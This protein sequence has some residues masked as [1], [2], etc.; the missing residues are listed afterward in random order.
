[1]ETVIQWISR[2]KTSLS[3][4]RAFLDSRYYRFRYWPIRYV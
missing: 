4:S 3:K 1:M 2:T